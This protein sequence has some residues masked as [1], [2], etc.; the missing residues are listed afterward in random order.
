MDYLLI[1]LT[2]YTI[3]YNNYN[4]KKKHCLLDTTFK[5]INT[6]FCR[7]HNNILTQVIE[8]I[9]CWVFGRFNSIFKKSA[10][11]FEEK[12]KK[13]NNEWERVKL[14]LRN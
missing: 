1:E 9:R 11:Y 12:N 3:N 10:K 6:Y 2:I 8:T 5:L 4:Y 14:L 7:Y 13:L